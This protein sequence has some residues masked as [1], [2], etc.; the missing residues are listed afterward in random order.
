MLLDQHVIAGSAA[1]TATDP[2]PRPTAA[3]PLGQPLKP[4]TSAAFTMRSIRFCR[5]RSKRAA[6]AVRYPVR[7]RDGDGGN[8]SST[9]GCTTEPGNAAS[10]GRYDV[11]TVSGGRSTCFCP[12]ASANR[13]RQSPPAPPTAL[14][15]PEPPR[16]PAR[17]RI[18]L[19]GAGL[20]SANV[21]A[22]APRSH[23]IG[24][25]LMIWAPR[26]SGE[27][28]HAIGWRPDRTGTDRMGPQPD[29]PLPTVRCA[30]VG[31]GSK[32]RRPIRDSTS[33]LGLV[34]GIR[35][36][37]V[38]VEPRHRAWRSRTEA[39]QHREDVRRQGDGGDADRECSS[40]RWCW[41][42]GLASLGCLA[43]GSWQAGNRPERPHPC[44]DHDS[45]VGPSRRPSAP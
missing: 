21:Q 30:S 4:P 44:T 9:T 20:T 8:F 41:R 10:R 12:A 28:G 32:T 42:N 13:A 18:D 36:Q 25:T 39:S 31:H 40:G 37:P 1:S 7:R 33:W 45:A 11:R 35:A 16:P 29:L 23:R 38:A 22:L 6:A 27:P 14:Q 17:S 2:P 34:R 5:R 3:R 19:G 24:D 26:S 43:V 15:P